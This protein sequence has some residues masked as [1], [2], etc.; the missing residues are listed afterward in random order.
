MAHGESCLWG[1]QSR[2]CAA[3]SRRL[4]EGA[5][6]IVWHRAI[7][8]ISVAALGISGNAGKSRAS[9]YPGML[10]GHAGARQR[11]VGA[12]NLTFRF[13]EAGMWRQLKRTEPPYAD[14][15]V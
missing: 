5:S 4:G 8:F 13:P 11:M 1:N 9:I 6:G 15:H 7:H 12:R 2:V 14:S 3:S 10:S